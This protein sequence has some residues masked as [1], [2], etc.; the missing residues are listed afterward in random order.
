MTKL[1]YIKLNGVSQ[2]DGNTYTTE[3]M[4]LAVIDLQLANTDGKE[5]AVVYQPRDNGGAFNVQASGLPLFTID[6]QTVD[7]AD[8]VPL[9][10]AQKEEVWQSLVEQAGDMSTK[11]VARMLVEDWDD[12]TWREE[13]DFFHEEDESQSV[14][15]HE[16]S[17]DWDQ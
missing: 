10:E 11:D 15:T 2:N 1:H 12:A 13:Y 3:A 4:K 17:G 5:Y 8:P 6:V 16:N 9:T 14:S 7:V